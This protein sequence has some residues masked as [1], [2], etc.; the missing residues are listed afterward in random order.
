MSNDRSSKEL[1]EYIIEADIHWNEDAKHTLADCIE[2]WLK[3]NNLTVIYTELKPPTT[4]GNW[5]VNVSEPEAGDYIYIEHE[6]HPGVIEVKAG[7]EGYSVIL[8]SDED[9]A[10]SVTE[11]W[12]TYYELEAQEE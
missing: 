5:V 1:A 9:D 7:D 10:D 12:A 4:I 2:E 11:T 6:Q 8:Y 3:Q